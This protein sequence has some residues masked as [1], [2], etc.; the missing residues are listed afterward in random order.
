MQVWKVQCFAVWSQ[1]ATVAGEEWNF[2]HSAAHHT[3]NTGIRCHGWS[4]PI[5]AAVSL[6]RQQPLS[7]IIWSRP[8]LLTISTKLSLWHWG[9]WHHYVE[10]SRTD[11]SEW[12]EHCRHRLFIVVHPDPNQVSNFLDMFKPVQPFGPRIR[13]PALINIPC[14]MIEHTSALV[15]CHG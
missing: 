6:L 12:L 1:T 3:E 15:V 2:E 4:Q 9:C 7:T 11:S 13:G 5:A 8:M 10:W 14:V